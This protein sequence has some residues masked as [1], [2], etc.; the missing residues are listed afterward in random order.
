MTGDHLEDVSEVRAA[1]D[2]KE[3][4]MDTDLAE[5]NEKHSIDAALSS[6]REAIEALSM[7]S[8]DIAEKKLDEKVVSEGELQS[9]AKD[10]SGCSLVSVPATSTPDHSC[11]PSRKRVKDSPQS[12]EKSRKSAKSVTGQ[13]A[14]K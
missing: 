3:T 2:A 4:S 12:L 13:I 6:A 14:G 9:T 11:T 1:A 5:K 10:G 8:V 7:S